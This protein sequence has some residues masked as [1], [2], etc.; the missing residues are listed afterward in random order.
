M[1]TITSASSISHFV[2]VNETPPTARFILIKGREYRS[3]CYTVLRRRE[4]VN[5]TRWL[6]GDQQR[7]KRSV[8]GHAKQ[9]GIS[10]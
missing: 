10:Y 5:Q 1:H 2:Y 3:L 6:A 7:G 4:M 8:L 9:T